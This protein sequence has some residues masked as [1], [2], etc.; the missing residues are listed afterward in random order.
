MA[1]KDINIRIGATDAASKVLKKVSS[2][3]S[4]MAKKAGE[5]AQRAGASMM[6]VG[7]SIAAAGGAIT[8]GL[9]KAVFDFSEAGDALD[10][11]SIRTG[12]SVEALSELSFAAQQSGTNIDQ[13]SQAMF[14]SFRRVGNAA[15]AGGGPAARALEELNLNAK[16]LSKLKPEKVFEKLTD[17]LGGVA[18]EAE[19]NQLGF[20]LFG[21]NFRQIQPLLSQGTDGIRELREEARRLGHNLTSEQAKAAADFTDAWSRVKNTLS[22]VKNQIGAALAPVLTRLADRTSAIVKLVINWVRNNPH[23]VKT[24]AAV[25]AAVTALGTTLVALGGFATAAGFALTGLGTVAS[26]IGAVIA[27]ALSPIGLAIA[28]ATAAVAALSAAWLVV[29]N[30][31][32]LLSA[33]IEALKDLFG[34]LKDAAVQTFAGISDA[35]KAGDWGLAMKIAMAGAKVAF[36]GGLHSIQ[37]SFLK[38]WPLMWETAKEFFKRF[39]KLA[40]RS[41]GA[42]ARAIA[43]P[44]SGAMEL[45]SLLASGAL[46]TALDISRGG[47]GDFLEG[48]KRAAQVELDTLTEQ[49]SQKAKDREQG[50]KQDET[51][52]KL[53]RL[54]DLSEESNR[55][56]PLEVVTVP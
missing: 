43:N 42:V 54:I 15:I 16:E 36:F 29:A 44:T 30:D 10:K 20:E 18:N 13:L 38:I 19:R 5:A 8:A 46:N 33:Q 34:V 9:G 48:K 39:A 1:G 11:M 26:G 37:Q 25:A 22:G 56:Q 17:A 3:V 50:K 24:L 31:T 52:I 51:N 6:R 55:Q 27:A 12:V 49:A 23:L 14:R 35:I 4:V 47:V 7:G 21:D 28:G 2:N 53:Q 32:G 41:T 40:I 45:T